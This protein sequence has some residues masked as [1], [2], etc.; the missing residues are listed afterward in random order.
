MRYKEVKG[1]WPLMKAKKTSPVEDEQSKTSIGTSS[2]LT[3]SGLFEKKDDENMMIERTL[4]IDEI[5]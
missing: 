3:G 1:H 5:S 4:P 2:Q